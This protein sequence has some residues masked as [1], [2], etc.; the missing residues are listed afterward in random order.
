MCNEDITEGGVYEYI[1]HSKIFEVVAIE[2]TSNNFWLVKFANTD[3]APIIVCACDLRDP[4]FY[5]KIE[6]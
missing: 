1:L 2:N 4:C 5:K 3:C 6:Q